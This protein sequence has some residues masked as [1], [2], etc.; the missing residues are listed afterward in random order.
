MAVALAGV[1]TAAA[2]SASSTY[3]DPATG[4]VTGQVWLVVRGTRAA[5]TVF[6]ADRQLVAHRDLRWGHSH[7]FTVTR[8]F[9]FVLKPG[10]YE[11]KVKYSDRVCPQKA[12]VV[13]RANRMTHVG[14]A[15]NC[16]G[17]TY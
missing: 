14:F 11:V 12:T 4:T 2:A 16:P 10:R 3:R 13:V 6:N 7:G 17:S 5:M 1:G 8:Y 9:R 15:E